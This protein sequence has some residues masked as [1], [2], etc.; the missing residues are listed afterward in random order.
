MVEHFG[1]KYSRI[2]ETVAEDCDESLIEN[3]LSLMDQ[4]TL[5]TPQNHDL[6]YIQVLQRSQSNL[7][8][9]AENEKQQKKVLC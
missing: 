1:Q 2:T 8:I 4:T 5:K 7:L 6:Q 9:R 3:I